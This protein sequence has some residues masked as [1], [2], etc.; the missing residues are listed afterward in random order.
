MASRG[1]FTKKV[2]DAGVMTGTTALTSVVTDLQSVLV[3]S[4]QMVWT[5]TAVGTFS[6]EVSNSYENRAG[7]ETGTW[8]VLTLDSAP[9]N[10]AGAGGDTG[11]D[12]SQLPYRYVRLKYTNASSTGVLNAWIHGKAA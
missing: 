3:A 10:P 4:Y 2:I 6:I 1:E 9:T 7:T 12:L 5:S 11:V 8:T